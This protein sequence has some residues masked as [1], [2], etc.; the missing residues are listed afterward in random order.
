MAHLSNTAT[1]RA[2]R[3]LAALESEDFAY[4]EPHLEFV[5]LHRKHVLYEAGEPIRYTYFPHDVVVSLVNV[6]EDGRSV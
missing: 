6:L 3:L 1:H 4:L 2:N 5:N